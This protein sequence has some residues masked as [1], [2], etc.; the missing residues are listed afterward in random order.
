MDT[1]EPVD[2]QTPPSRWTGK[3]IVGIA[4][5]VLILLRVAIDLVPIRV[6]IS[7]ETTVI[8]GPLREDGTPDYEAYLN[9]HWSEGVTP[10]NNAAVDLIRAFGPGIIDEDTREAYF[11]QLG[12]PIPPLEGDYYV[13]FHEFMT[14][15]GS[16]WQTNVDEYD[17]LSQMMDHAQAREWSP[18]EFLEIEKWLQ[19]NK[20]PLEVI[21]TATNKPLYFSTLVS[22][23]DQ[24]LLYAL[25]PVTQQTESAAR[26]IITKAMF[27]L[28]QGNTDRALELTLACH[29]LARLVS[30]H[31]TLSGS[32]VAYADDA[33]ASVG[34]EQ[35]I[36]SGQLTAAEANEY[37]NKLSLLNEFRPMRDVINEGE[38]FL[39]L[40][41]ACS[42]HS[43]RLSSDEVGLWGG[44]EQFAIRIGFT[45]NPALLLFN[46]MYDEIN[47]V[48]QLPDPV[49]RIRGL[50]T[51]EQRL[52]TNANPDKVKLLLG[53]MVSTRHAIGE[54]VGGILVTMMA[55][56]IMEAVIAEERT[57]INR[58]LVGLGYALAAHRAEAG[59]FPQSL[60]ELV[61]QQMDALPL[62][63]FSG[64]PFRY[65]LTDNGFLLY[66]VGPNTFDDNGYGNGNADD[67]PFGDRPTDDE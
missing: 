67:T 48:M 2:D 35:I 44:S 30:M 64:K 20:Q 54:A 25:L 60:E 22:L 12:I 11:E 4:V 62:D 34:D 29:R 19:V 33:I 15:N 47:T 24:G 49:E 52:G 6:H 37:R 42:L 59:S 41:A 13:D 21:L 14:Q 1:F 9:A 51:V 26:L 18:D 53:L 63:P 7:P 31:P 40:D 43:G 10:E 8:D 27:E 58:Q 28:Q 50:E 56:F 46:Q 57:R 17:R 36:L 65:R 66:S 3:R 38:R 55:P 45:P 32:L 23:D 5:T 61:P 39:S 16:D